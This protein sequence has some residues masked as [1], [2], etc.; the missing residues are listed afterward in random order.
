MFIKSKVVIFLVDNPIDSNALIL[1]KVEVIATKVHLERQGNVEEAFLYQLLNCN[2]TVYLA[3][4][5]DFKNANFKTNLKHI[6][7]IFITFSKHSI[8]FE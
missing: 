2:C 7:C 3:F 8:T 1:H 5:V 4:V 6:K